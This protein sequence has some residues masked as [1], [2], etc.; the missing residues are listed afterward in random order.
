MVP[1]APWA[2]STAW[3][4]AG[5]SSR[6][7]LALR[8]PGRH[9]GRAVGDHE[10]AE[11]RRLFLGMFGRQH[12]APG[13]AQQ[14]VA[15]RNPE[16][17]QDR[18]EL[19]EEQGHRPDVGRRVGQMGREPA[20]DLVVVNDGSALGG[21]RLEAVDVIMR[22]SGAA[23]Q[24]HQRRSPAIDRTRDAIPGLVIPH[25]D[26]AFS[27]LHP[28]LAF[29]RAA[30]AQG[31][32]YTT[33][34]PGGQGP[35]LRGAEA[36]DLLSACLFTIGVGRRVTQGQPAIDVPGSRSGPP[37]RRFGRLARSSGQRDEPEGP[38]PFS[39]DAS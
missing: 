16:M 6:R 9:R 37:D 33:L 31:A 22:G 17:R 11:A 26:S 4:S 30:G 24:D 20:A 18:I 21:E 34:W 13:L 10:A 35:P 3:T 19:A 12:A 28:P 23:V 8:E 1:A 14:V 7:R 27:P 15:P 39:T 25:P 36:C 32:H 29:D 38:A 2:R 5:R